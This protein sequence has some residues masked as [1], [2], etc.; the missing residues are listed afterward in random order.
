MSVFDQEL[1]PGLSMKLVSFPGSVECLG[2]DF[3]FC[4]KEELFFRVDL[5]FPFV[6]PSFHLL[7]IVLEISL[8]CLDVIIFIYTR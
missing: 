7:Q 4:D 8:N 1:N 5:N 3:C 6:E 2:G